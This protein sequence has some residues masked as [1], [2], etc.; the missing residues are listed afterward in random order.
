MI[1]DVEN[2]ILLTVL[3]HS[4]I[5][6]LIRSVILAGEAIPAFSVHRQPLLLTFE[7]PVHDPT[8][9]D[10]DQKLFPFFSLRSI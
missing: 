2:I 10:K 8:A 7:R 9:S 6:A 5:F 1:C 4:S 3:P